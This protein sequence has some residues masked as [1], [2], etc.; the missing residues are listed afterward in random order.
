MWRPGSNWNGDGLM[1]YITT[2]TDNGMLSL[3]AK[4]LQRISPIIKFSARDCRTNNKH[5]IHS[6]RDLH[7][8]RNAG[9]VTEK[10]IRQG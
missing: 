10:H 1:T 5:A 4:L 7:E 8:L 3:G 9:I 2:P 6:N